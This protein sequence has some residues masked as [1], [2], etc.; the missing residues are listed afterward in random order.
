MRDEE[1][2][3]GLCVCNW[4][5]VEFRRQSRYNEAV[6]DDQRSRSSGYTWFDWRADGFRG[7]PP[8]RRGYRPLYLAISLVVVFGLLVLFWLAFSARLA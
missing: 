5:K 4:P 1:S 3:A 7:P 2:L 6:E 8:W